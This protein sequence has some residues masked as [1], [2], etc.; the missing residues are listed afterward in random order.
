MYPYWYCQGS[1][2]HGWCSALWQKWSQNGEVTLLQ[3]TQI[4]LWMHWQMMISV[5][6]I[7]NPNPSSSGKCQWYCRNISSHGFWNSV[8]KLFR[9]MNLVSEY[10]NHMAMQEQIP[11]VTNVI[12]TGAM[13]VPIYLWGDDAVYNQRNE[14]NVAVVC[15]SWLDER[16]KSKD[17]VSPFVHI[18]VRN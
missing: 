6:P 1:S 18:P 15:G 11:W 13:Y 2:H 12:S 8:H 9:V 17:T 16:K 5:L 10:W 4:S 7:T 3:S 14:K